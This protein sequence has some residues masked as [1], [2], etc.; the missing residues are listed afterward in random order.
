MSD[1]II[2]LR[3]FDP[4][5]DYPIVENWWKAHGWSAVPKVMLPKLG[6]MAFYA[7]DKIEDAAAAWLYMDNSSPVCMLEWLVANP[8]L[9]A[10]KTVRA[11]KHVCQF[12]TSEAK[13][14][15]YAVMLTTCKQ[16]GLVKFHERQGFHKTDAEM[17]HLLKVF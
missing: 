10:T 9:S 16:E 1:A 11:L 7:S 5:T 8:S 6:V 12:L 2:Q 3:A 13:H 15:G 4:E 17:T 14:N